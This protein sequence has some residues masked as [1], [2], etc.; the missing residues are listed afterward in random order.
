MLS[1]ANPLPL[2]A[3]DVSV[4]FVG[5]VVKPEA[6]VF[7]AQNVLLTQLPQWLPCLQE[8]LLPR[9]LVVLGLFVS[10]WRCCEEIWP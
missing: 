3:L 9:W 7:A 4:R 5:A 1:L 8:M 6:G 10:D 2:G